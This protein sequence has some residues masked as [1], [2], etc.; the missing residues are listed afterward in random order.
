MHEY[1]IAYDIYLTSRRAALDHQA[2]RV[3][4][5]H[6]EMGELAMANPEQVKF[7][8]GAITEEDPLFV[9]T[10]LACHAVAPVVRCTCGYEGGELYICPKCG[11]LPDLVRGREIVVTNIEVEVGEA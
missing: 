7:L 11:N 6:V 4:Q 8:F 5:V 9:G 10:E 2:E 3:L 1:S